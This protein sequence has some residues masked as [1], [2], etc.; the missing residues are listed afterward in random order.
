MMNGKSLHIF[1]VSCTCNDNT[2]HSYTQQ[3]FL[4]AHHCIY[5]HLKL[6]SCA[7]DMYT[8]QMQ[9][10]NLRLR[11]TC[12][13]YEAALSRK[14]KNNNNTIMYKLSLTLTV[15]RCT[16]VEKLCAFKCMSK[17]LL[18]FILISVI[19]RNTS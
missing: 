17:V 14:K 8:H 1:Y 13:D 11:V 7:M 15:T 2:V 10:D 5:L 4:A 18:I 12:Y 16:H 3:L 6:F 9:C 19:N